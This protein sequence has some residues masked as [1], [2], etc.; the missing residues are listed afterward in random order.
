VPEQ[1]L[2]P[3]ALRQRPLPLRGGPRRLG[4]L[5]LREPPAHGT[6]VVLTV[7]YPEGIPGADDEEPEGAG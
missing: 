7:V 5:A 2:R 3:R 1:L 4:L 6:R